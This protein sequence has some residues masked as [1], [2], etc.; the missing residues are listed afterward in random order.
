[1]DPP[2][3]DSHHNTTDTSAAAEAERSVASSATG[4]QPAAKK[5]QLRIQV[6][7]SS[8]QLT[9]LSP[10][11]DASTPSGLKRRRTVP[12]KLI[13]DNGTLCL[14]FAEEGCASHAHTHALADG[15]TAITVT[16]PP[17]SK[18]PFVGKRPRGR[19][20]LSNR[21]RGSPRFPTRGG[22]GGRGRP[23]L[24]SPSAGAGSPSAA[25][26]EERPRS[27]SVEHATQLVLSRLMTGKLPLP[28][29]T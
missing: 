24:R 19:P 16:P 18:S 5:T 6:D 20:P 4:A 14:A 29:A 3:G 21:G 13:E 2:G 7:D 12:A 28:P 17:G 15:W 22:G 11:S 23:P 1:M 27:T 10:G 26:G 8:A 25:A 9:Q